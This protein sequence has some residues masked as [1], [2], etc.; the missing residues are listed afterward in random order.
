MP[1]STGENLMLTRCP[2][3]W[4]L[5]AVFLTLALGTTLLAH[6]GVQDAPGDARS[7]MYP[8]AR[9]GGNYMH[10]Y[11]FPMAPSSTPWYPAWTP[12]GSRITVS[13]AGSIWNVDPK[14]GIADELVFDP[15][16]LSSPA[17]SPDGRWLVYTADDD[18]QTIQLGIFNA[19]TGEHRP[20]TTDSFIYT[21]PV[22][23]PDGT[24]LAYVSTRPNG[25]FNVFVRPIKNGQWAGEEMMVT[26]DNRFPR[27]RLYFGFWDLHVQP[28]WTRDG[29][30]LLVV[31]NRG[32]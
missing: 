13:M 11:Y 15:K 20:L 17:W 22:F 9:S 23:S 8:S 32:V 6:W 2:R 30:H 21:D 4:T 10:N 31:S 29:Q 12:D 18:G 25:S 7:R 16:Y 19:A 24:R 26:T 5:A 28:A 3:Q 27:N 1:T 14:T